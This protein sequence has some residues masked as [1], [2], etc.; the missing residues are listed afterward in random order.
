MVGG[1]DPFGQPWRLGANEA[2]ALHLPFA[3]EIGGVRVEPGSY[4]LYAIPGESEWQIVV[5]RNVERWGIPIND[6]VRGGDVG[7]ATVPVQRLE[8]H[9]ETLTMSF[10]TPSRNST[11]L[12]VEWER[13]RVRIP[14]RRT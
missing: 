6:V 7:S 14:I 8:E 2:T 4:S 13:T 1:Q 12:I 10:A 5:N 11:E 3:A 9:V